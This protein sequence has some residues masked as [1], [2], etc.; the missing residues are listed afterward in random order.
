MRPNVENPREDAGAFARN[1]IVG[2]NLRVKQTPSNINTSKAEFARDYP[3]IAA[4]WF[5]VELELIQ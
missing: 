3:I 1:W 4:H 2:N 5:G